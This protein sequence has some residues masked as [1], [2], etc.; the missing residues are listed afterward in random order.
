MCQVC[1]QTCPPLQVTLSS[2]YVCDRW[3]LKS[4]EPD[5]S[6]A[7]SL[8]SEVREN[9]EANRMWKTL[10]A[11]SIYVNDAMEAHIAM[12]RL[13]QNGSRYPL[14][15]LTLLPDALFRPSFATAFAASTTLLSVTAAPL[16]L[17]RRLK[18][19]PS[20]QSIS[21]CSLSA[22]EQVQLLLTRTDWSRI[23]LPQPTPSAVAAHVALNRH[24]FQLRVGKLIA[25][26]DLRD[27]LSNPHLTSFISAR[28]IPKNCFEVL[29]P[30]QNLTHIVC[31]ATSLVLPILPCSV[32][33]LLH[34]GRN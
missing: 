2:P 27:C 7:S 24:A 14:L 4:E 20:V 29:L 6:L 5:L 32:S 31:T 30:C 34:I 26:E 17:A 16:D 3:K 11:D 12:L 19:M 10:T 9:A 1:L 22:S 18:S 23:E 8:L 21:Q 15:H 28:R 25:S 13:R 33:V